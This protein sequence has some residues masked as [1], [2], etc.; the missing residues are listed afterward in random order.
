MVTRWGMSELGLVAFRADE[1]QPFLG[2]EIAQGR[3][4]SEATAARIDE[5]VL[6]LLGQAHDAIR[7]RLEGARE[8][9]DQLVDALLREETLSTEEPE[10]ILG[11]RAESQ[12]ETLCVAAASIGSTAGN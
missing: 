3:D 12:S 2:H 6:R 9:L 1:Q 11:P 5:E 4:Y 8:Q 10:Q 7:G